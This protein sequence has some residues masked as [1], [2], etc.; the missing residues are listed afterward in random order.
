MKSFLKILFLYCMY[1]IS[2]ST[3]VLGILTLFIPENKIISVGLIIIGM[4]TFWKIHDTLG[5]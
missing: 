4:I 2:L 1:C 3:I 5:L